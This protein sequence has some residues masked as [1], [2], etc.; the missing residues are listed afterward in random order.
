MEEIVFKELLKDTKFCKIEYF[1]KSIVVNNLSRE[2]T[3]EEVKESVLKLILY[4]F[5]KIDITSKTDC[6]TKEDNFYEAKELGSVES[7][8]EQKRSLVSMT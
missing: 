5:I 7:W 3:Y 2:I 6:I 1:I 4:R 8:L